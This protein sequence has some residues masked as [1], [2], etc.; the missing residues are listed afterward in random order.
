MEDNLKFKFVGKT[1]SSKSSDLDRW[2]CPVCRKEE[3]SEC[4]FNLNPKKRGMVW[5]CRFCGS[6]LLLD[7]KNAL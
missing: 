2:E 6:R 7:P 4:R 3:M 5:K 1:H